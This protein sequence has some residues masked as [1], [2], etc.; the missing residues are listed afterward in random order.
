MSTY[1]YFKVKQSIYE[2]CSKTAPKGHFSFADM[3]RLLT[4]NGWIMFS[5]LIVCAIAYSLLLIIFPKSLYFL[6]PFCGIFAWM[7]S[8]E[9]WGNKMFNPSERKKSWMRVMP[10]W[11]IIFNTSK[12]S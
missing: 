12:K 5:L 8:V 1:R 7:S 11:K 4:T 6:I 9:L 3:K 10:N 2:E